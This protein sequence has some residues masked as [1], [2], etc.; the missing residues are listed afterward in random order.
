MRLGGAV[1]TRVAIGAGTEVAAGTAAAAGAGVVASWLTGIGLVLTIAAVGVMIYGAIMEDDDA[2]KFLRK[3][4]WG[5]YGGGEDARYASLEDELGAFRH[6]QYG[7]KAEL[8][9]EDGWWDWIGGTGDEV[10]LSIL[11]GQFEPGVSELDYQLK[12]EGNN[13]YPSVVVATGTYTGGAPGLP[14]EGGLQ[15]VPGAPGAKYLSIK[16]NY[17]ID[18]KKVSLAV[19]DYKY[20]PNGRSESPIAGQVKVA[21]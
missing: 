15:E 8:K 10:Q 2:E 21:D 11:I 18:S 6:Y 14:L 7:V 3:S 13:K 12:L 1:A 5:H 16:T 4:Y 20:F 9:W 17:G 19:L